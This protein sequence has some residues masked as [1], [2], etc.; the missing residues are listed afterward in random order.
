LPTSKKCQFGLDAETKT[1]ID[2]LV[3]ER[4]EA[5]KAKDF[6]KSDAIRDEIMA[7]G[8][9]IMDTA[10]GTFWERVE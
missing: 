3:E 4:T 1:K 6:E 7:F 10:Q 9:S 5:K 8:I 2:N